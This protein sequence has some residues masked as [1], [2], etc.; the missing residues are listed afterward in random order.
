MFH[1]CKIHFHVLCK[2]VHRF[3]IHKLTSYI[4][5][6]VPLKLL[7]MLHLQIISGVMRGF[8]CPL[9]LQSNWKQVTP[10]MRLWMPAFIFSQVQQLMSRVSIAPLILNAIPS[11]LSATNF[12]LFSD[13][14]KRHFF[15]ANFILLLAMVAGLTPQRVF[16]VFWKTDLV[17]PPRAFWK[18][19]K[20]CQNFYN[21]IGKWCYWFKHT[22][23]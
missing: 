1:I 14:A 2:L 22:V 17:F 4:H 13:L 7:D 9:F 19:R 18:K 5:V 10:T 11:E 8:D 15:T 3:S 6:Y 23:V 21:L 20:I 16:L 12:A